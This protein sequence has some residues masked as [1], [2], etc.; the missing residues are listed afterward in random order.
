MKIRA[1]AFFLTLMSTASAH[2]ICTVEDVSSAGVTGFQE[3]VI[4]VADLDAA[5]ETWQTVGGYEMICDGPVEPGVNGDG[6][7]AFWGLPEDTPMHQV[8]LR[9]GEGN[10]GLLRLVKIYGQEQVQIRSS[11]MPWDHGGFFD[12]YVYVDDVDTVFAQLRDRG[13]Q[14]Y[15]DTVHYTLQ[16]FDINEVIA[17]GPNGEALVLMQRNAPPY[18]KKMMGAE[19]GM[20]WPFNTALIVSDYEANLRFFGD[21][22]A[23]TVHLSGLSTTPPPGFNPTGIPANLA[24]ENG[25]RFAAFA[26]SRTDRNGSIQI[27]KAQGLTGRD[28][29][30]R[31]EP[32]NLGILTMRVPLPNMKALNE[33]V[34][35]AEAKRYPIHMPMTDLNLPPYG[36]VKILAYKAPNGARIEFFTQQ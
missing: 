35:L 1:A 29:T 31:A 32:P 5:N 2:A 17:R 27:L 30:D 3:A 6:L 19:S 10:R 25:R 18:D 21:V 33:V 8:V 16:G 34:A 15:N 24:M 23:W 26:N 7:A 20:S 36:P 13:W 4:S 12:L 28:F 22:L 14:G 9:K 11:G